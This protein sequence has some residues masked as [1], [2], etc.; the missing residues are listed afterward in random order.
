MFSPLVPN[1]WTCTK[2]E[3]IPEVE[4]IGHRETLI[5]LSNWRH[6][7]CPQTSSEFVF[8]VKRD[9]KRQLDCWE[10]I[11][12]C[13]SSW[14]SEKKQSRT[15]QVAFLSLPTRSRASC[16]LERVFNDDF[17]VVVSH[18]SRVPLELQTR[19]KHLL[20]TLWLHHERE[21]PPP[22]L[23][24]GHQESHWRSKIQLIKQSILCLW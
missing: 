23:V 9:F 12:F 4:Q 1:G 14:L 16:R 18:Q 10:I 15:R 5:E 19:P 13:S 22:L 20:W 3:V 7:L 11:F 17:D 8:P 6:A 21:T 24:V 2:V